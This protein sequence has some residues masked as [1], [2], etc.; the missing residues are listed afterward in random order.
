VKI[1]NPKKFGIRFRG[2][3][4]ALKLQGSA[5]QFHQSRAT[6]RNETITYTYSKIEAFI[7]NLRPVR[8]I[9][10]QVGGGVIAGEGT[11][12]LQ[13]RSGVVRY[14]ETQI[15]KSGSLESGFPSLFNEGLLWLDAVT[16]TERSGSLFR[17]PSPDP[18]FVAL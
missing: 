11:F 7:G 15:V 5:H 8:R 4:A 14:G 16:Y 12:R 17:N 18:A 2:T 6:S 10:V 13:S 3:S 9:R 1:S